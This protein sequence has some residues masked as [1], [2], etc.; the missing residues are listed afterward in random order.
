MLLLGFEGG[1]AT[2]VES[3]AVIVGVRPLLC[4]SLLP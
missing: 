3:G 2:G 4:R 1:V